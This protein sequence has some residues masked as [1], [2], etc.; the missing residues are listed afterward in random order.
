VTTR[1]IM[2]CV[3]VILFM[4]TN[5]AQ[6]GHE[7][8]IRVDSL[9]GFKFSSVVAKES[10][11]KGKKVIEVTMPS[12]LYQDPKKGSSGNSGKEVCVETTVTLR[13]LDGYEATREIQEGTVV[14]IR[15]YPASGRLGR[16]D[17]A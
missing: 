17:A 5:L 8:N 6:A 9:K 2:S 13:Y 7:D 12:K 3:A 11:Y 14:Q 4:G 15:D 1:F 10:A 16:V